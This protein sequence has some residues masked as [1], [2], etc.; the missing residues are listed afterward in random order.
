[1][2]HDYIHPNQLITIP[3]AAE[4]LG[5]PTSTLRRAVKEGL[6]PSVRVFNTRRRVRLADILDA[7][8]SA[9]AQQ[10]LLEDALLGGLHQ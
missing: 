10:D 1:M 7:I 8:Q 2:A 4:A 5:I 6:V 9:E 3:A